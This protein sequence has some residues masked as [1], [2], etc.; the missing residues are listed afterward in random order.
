MQNIYKY[1]AASVLSGAV[2]AGCSAEEASETIKTEESAA[3]VEVKSKSVDTNP[4]A[5]ANEV[6][7]NNRE[8]AV[9]V[10]ASLKRILDEPM[11][12]TLEEKG[13][14][15]EYDWY[16]KSKLVSNEVD[17]FLARQDEPKSSDL[18]NVRMLA[19]MIGHLQYV[20]TAHIDDT[21]GETE[22]QTAVEDWKP[23][24]LGLNYSYMYMKRIVHDLDIALNH[25][26]QGDTYGVTYLLKGEKLDELKSFMNG[27][28]YVGD[29]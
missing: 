13:F 23:A 19:G 25:D 18:R 14:D 1:V 5:K 29:E 10:V 9:K 28:E 24:S 8:D 26:G 3:S 7:M 16:L 21:G 2:L 15:K 4:E 17:R 20:R 12:P 6:V 22:A 11:D 27:G